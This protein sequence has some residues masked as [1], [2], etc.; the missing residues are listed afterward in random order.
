MIEVA[1][2]VITPQQEYT[3]EDASHVVKH[4]GNTVTYKIYSLSVYLYLL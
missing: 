4:V 1:H 2:L 3:R